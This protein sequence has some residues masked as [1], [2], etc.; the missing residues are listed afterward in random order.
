VKEGIHPTWYP[1]AVVVCS[2]GNTWTT[3]STKKEIHTDICNKCHPFYTGEQRIVDTAG[4]VE[5]FMKRMTAKEQIAAAQPAPEDKKSKKEKR[6]ERK[7]PEVPAPVAVQAPAELPLAV[8]EEKPAVVETP[9]VAEPVVVKEPEA[10]VA[11]V[12]EPVI[13]TIIA[14]VAKIEEPVV[15]QKVE[16]VAVV[17]EPVAEIVAEPVAVE[18]VVEEPVV[19]V[20]V[21]EEP[22]V[23]VAVI[24]EPVAIVHEPVVVKEPEA[25]F[26]QV[27]EPVVETIVAPVAKIEEPVVET[28]IAPVAKIEEP[29]P[30]VVETP[31]TLAVTPTDDLEIIEGIGPK[32][33]SVLQ[34]AGIK[35]F[36]EL[37][38]TAVAKLEEILH[39]AQ[40]SMADPSTWA[41]Q[42]KL[43]ADGKMAELKK[44]Q[45]ELTGGRRVEEEEKP[46]KARAAK[47][48]AAKKVAEKKPAAKAE[49]KPKTA[50]KKPAAKPKA[51]TTKKAK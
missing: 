21:A 12:E 48:P 9:V 11:K 17:Q 47:K 24:E 4:Q 15:E 14:P 49:A 28:I 46:A 25:P 1:D 16:P 18:P 50:A 45:D 2:C 37:A 26:A 51:S 6:R 29:A 44:L 36:A 3:A 39:S 7:T 13:E 34:D 43:A 30:V 33:A 27:E 20:A 22:V 41:E 31:K 42:A 23:P 38:E 40:L 5:R 19:P 10:P 8:I 32:I 35:T